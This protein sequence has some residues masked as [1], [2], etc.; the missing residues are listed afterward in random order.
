MPSNKIIRLC[1]ILFF[2][3]MPHAVQADAP[4][5]PPAQRLSDFDAGGGPAKGFSGDIKQRGSIDMTVDPEK[6]ANGV[7][8]FR[9]SK[10]SGKQ[11]G[12]AH[13]VYR[14]DPVGIGSTV[15]MAARV[16]F[17]SAS[18]VNSVTLMDLECANCG[19]DTNPGVRLYLRDGLLRVDR[20]KIGIQPA[21]L[22]IANVQVTKSVWHQITWVV[23]LGD[24]DTGSAA[25]LAQVYLDDVLV[26]DATGIT[27]LTQAAVDRVGG[28]GF[29]VRSLVDRFQIG[30]TANSNKSETTM[31]V[32]DVSFCVQ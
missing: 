12:K 4:R 30:L 6:A 24:S 13:L 15:T 32:D 16:Y 1:I 28:G 19:L 9:A 10:K 11:V 17:P 2:A 27:V 5:C 7:V 20:S 8:T 29:Q 26:L 25:G 31:L 14:F 21:F 23:R 18:A 22:P 3:A